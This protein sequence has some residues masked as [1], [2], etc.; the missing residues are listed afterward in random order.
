M[1]LLCCITGSIERHRRKNLHFIVHDAQ[2]RFIDLLL[3]YPYEKSCSIVAIL[4]KLNDG[5]LHHIMKYLRARKSLQESHTMI[6]NGSFLAF[7]AAD[8][9]LLRSECDHVLLTILVSRN[10]IFYI[11]RGSIVKNVE[12]SCKQQIEELRRRNSACTITLMYNDVGEPS[13][14][15]PSRWWTITL[16]NHHV[17]VPSRWCTI[18]LVYHHVGEH[19]RGK[20]CLKVTSWRVLL[21]LNKKARYNY[22]NEINQ[23]DKKFKN[24]SNKIRTMRVVG[25]E[26]MHIFCNNIYNINTH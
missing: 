5:I 7:L 2:I 19:I 18:T 21:F 22:I 17:D 25:R 9:G 6:L 13:R 15:V 23:T 26:N 11:V 8:C 10:W 14:W 3:C 4:R 1:A 20:L 12:V 16:M 24:C